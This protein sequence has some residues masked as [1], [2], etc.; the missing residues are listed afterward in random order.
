MAYYLY[1]IRS[2]KDGWLYV[3]QTKNLKARLKRHNEGKVQ[4]TKNRGPFEIEYFEKYETRGEAMKR[5]RY[6]KSPKGGVK[7]RELI[8]NETGCSAVV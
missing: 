8:K 1:V 4:S 5:E 3:G 2:L 7:K 6:F